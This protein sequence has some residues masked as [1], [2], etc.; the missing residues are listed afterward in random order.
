MPEDS[1]ESEESEESEESIGSKRFEHSWHF[2]TK[3]IFRRM[4]S[5]ELIIEFS[6][7]ELINILNNA[8]TA[9][10]SEII[11]SRHI[12]LPDV[13]VKYRPAMSNRLGENEVIKELN[14]Q[15]CHILN[16]KWIVCL[17]VLL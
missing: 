11:A 17:Q 9:M 2:L 1:D 7:Q 4:D 3:L 16:S 8:F 13:E 14:S 5:N 12:I 10:N 15:T 6:A